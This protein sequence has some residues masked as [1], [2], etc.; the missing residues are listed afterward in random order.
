MEFLTKF[1]NVELSVRYLHLE[2]MV[3]FQM[4]RSCLLQKDIRTSV[5]AKA[6]SYGLRH[7]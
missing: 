3:S 1:V 2:G 5:K 7:N 6:A 4:V